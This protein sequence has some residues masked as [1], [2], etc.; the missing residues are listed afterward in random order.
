MAQHYRVIAVDLL[1]FSRSSQPRFNSAQKSGDSAARRAQRFW[2]DSLENWRSAMQIERFAVVGHSLG[3]YVALSFALERP[4]R[5][6]RLVLVSPFGLLEDTALSRA[7]ALSLRFRVFVRL[8]ALVSPHTLIRALGPLGRAV[9][10][11][12]RHDDV[13][14]GFGDRRSRADVVVSDRKSTRLNSSHT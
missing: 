4:R 3:A 8:M 1:G 5:V 10:R 11:F 9:M 2:I 7:A 12:F 13:R 6:S 14:Y